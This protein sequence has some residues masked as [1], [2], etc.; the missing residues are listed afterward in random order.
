MMG[1]RRSA[2]HT[3]HARAPLAVLAALFAILLQTFAVQTHVHITPLG[4]APAAHAQQAPDS[5]APPAIAD[6]EAACVL[7]QAMAA[8]GRALAPAASVIVTTAIIATHE[9]APRDA[10]FVPI[11]AA[12]AWRSRAPPTRL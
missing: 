6:H 9:A 4:L 1:T 5:E 12:F 10:A 8:S 3:P 2:R 11:L 7:C